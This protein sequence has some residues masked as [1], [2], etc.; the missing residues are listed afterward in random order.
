MLHFEL[1]LVGA[2]EFIEHACPQ[3]VAIRIES[4]VLFICSGVLWS[5]HPRLDVEKMG[6]TFADF[7][8]RLA[9]AGGGESLQRSDLCDHLGHIVTM[10]LDDIVPRFCHDG[11]LGKQ[12][13]KGLTL[14]PGPPSDGVRN[15]ELEISFLGRAIHSAKRAVIF[16][17]AA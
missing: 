13:E 16:S 12:E 8:Q 2:H 7:V 9:F 11:A 17:T 3:Q 10:L 14:T 6:E 5:K 4:D 1:N 15:E